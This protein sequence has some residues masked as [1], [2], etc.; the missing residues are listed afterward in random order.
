M[1]D[2]TAISRFLARTALASALAA[3]SACATYTAHPLETRAAAQTSLA[4]LRHAAAPPD[5]LGI[6]DVEQLAL[7]N[8]PELI[9]A[10]TQHGLSQAQLRTAG[11]LP[12][13]VFNA[14]YQDVLSGPGMFAALAAGLS[15]DLKSLVTLSSKRH[16]A[17][18][19]AQSVDAAI[20]WQEWQTVGKARLS[21]LDLIEGDKA[22]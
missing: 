2:V 7:D 8:N 16:A 14:S 6:A 3:L 19:S 22:A 15:Q 5:R 18:K 12:N 9:A 20:L 4:D 1:L 21:A 17:Q 13:P 11:I 10:R